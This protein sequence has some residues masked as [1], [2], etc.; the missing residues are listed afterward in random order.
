[1]VGTTYQLGNLV[2]AA[3]STIESKL[4]EKYPL[5]PAPNGESRYNYG[6][7][8]GIMVV[9]FQTNLAI[10]MGVVYGALIIIM[11]VG[12]ER[13][14]HDAIMEDRKKTE[15]AQQNLREKQGKEGSLESRAPSRKESNMV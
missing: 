3:S 10:F 1:M 7:V 2:S 6:T 5:P 9:E 14:H 8:M 11:I 13:L 12:P 15:E 4:G